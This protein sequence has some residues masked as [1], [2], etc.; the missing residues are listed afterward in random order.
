MMIEYDYSYRD[1]KILSSDSTD[2]VAP[3]NYVRLLIT[4]LFWSSRWN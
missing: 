4:S 1:L 3:E 2:T